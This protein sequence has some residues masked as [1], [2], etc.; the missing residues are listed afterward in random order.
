VWQRHEL[1]VP[2]PQQVAAEARMCNAPAMYERN[3]AAI[4]PTSYGDV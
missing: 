4:L 1:N 2:L 3:I